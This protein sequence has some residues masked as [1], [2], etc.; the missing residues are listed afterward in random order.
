MRMQSH[1]TELT[2]KMILKNI[3]MQLTSKNVVGTL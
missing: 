2:V 3:I 1:F